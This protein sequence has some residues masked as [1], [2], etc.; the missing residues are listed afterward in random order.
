MTVWKSTTFGKSRLNLQPPPDGTCSKLFEYISIYPS[1]KSPQKTFR[2]GRQNCDWTNFLA[3]TLKP[4]IFFYSQ[5]CLVAT[6]RGFLLSQGATI[7]ILW[8]AAICHVGKLMPK[9]IGRV[10]TTYCQQ[11]NSI[12]CS[13]FNVKC[14]LLMLKLPKLQHPRKIKSNQKH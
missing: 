10:V 5:F 1:E 11:R 12:L 9:P 4:T 13:S 8:L 7:S 6:A 3:A 2:K 14:Y